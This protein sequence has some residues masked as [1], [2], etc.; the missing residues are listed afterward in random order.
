M[1]DMNLIYKSNSEHL[2]AEDLG[3]QFYTLTINS[4]DV[5]EFENG[6]RKIVLQFLETE[7]TLPLNVTNARAIADMYGQDTDQWVRR[8]IMLFSMMV[9]FQDKMVPGI[10]IRA[11][12]QPQGFT[13]G[14]PAQQPQ[15]QPMNQPVQQPPA[16][17]W[18]EANPP[19][20]GQPVNN[21]QASHSPLAKDLDD[22]IP[23]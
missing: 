8:Q 23:F 10:R 4:A 16:G 18:T 12:Q 15:G 5:R 14:L 19:P 21:T 20:L 11:P 22:E 6:D 17:G 7:K 3:N 2:K 1:V 13:S 9:S